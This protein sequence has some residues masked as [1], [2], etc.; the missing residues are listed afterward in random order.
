MRQ[1]QLTGMYGYLGSFVTLD[2][3]QA[4]YPAPRLSSYAFVAEKIYKYT[5]TGWG[6]AYETGGETASNFRD[7]VMQASG[8]NPAAGNLRML[9][10]TIKR[11]FTRDSS[12]VEALVC[13]E[14]GWQPEYQGMACDGVDDYISIAD[15]ANLN[16]PATP[17][18]QEFFV[19]MPSDVTT[20]QV[21]ANKG[22]K[23]FAVTIGNG[24]LRLEKSSVT[25]WGGVSI[26][27]HAGKLLYVIAGWDGTNRLISL[28]GQIVQSAVQSSDL[29]ESVTTSQGIGS[30]SFK[31]A[32]YLAR[33]WNLALTASE[34]LQLYNN[35][36]PQNSVILSKYR[37]A[38]QTIRTSGA[39]T[40]GKQYQI[41]SYVSGDSFTNVGAASNATGVTF[42]ATGTTPT[43]WTNASQLKQL[44]TVLELKGENMG[45]VSATD[46][47]GNR[48]H[49]AMN[50][51]PALTVNPLQQKATT[52]VFTTNIAAG[53][54]N[55]DIIIP[56]GYYVTA[57]TV[58]NTLASGNLT[59]A[60][61]V[62]DPTGDNITLITGKTVNN[63][64]T[65]TFTALADQTQSTSSRVVRINATGNGTGGMEVMLILARRD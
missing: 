58:A 37:G 54:A 32:I 28:N 9:A 55:K 31:G 57:I 41:V 2:D 1:K 43:T 4:R 15:N 12:G 34:V 64:K 61:A 40:V 26:S 49:G 17:F 62:L 8:S 63:A 10:K 50:G 7:Y 33:F 53:T 48:L 3:L 35:G 18:M 14:S 16:F 24:L 60:Q 27:Q 21:L 6:I 5:S 36:Q 52:G 11:M 19:K 56:A 47:S 51:T 25:I 29:I 46:T 22:A 39:L 38:S 30:P 44:G 20:S 45:H 23:G 59:N 13:D 42:V 65:L